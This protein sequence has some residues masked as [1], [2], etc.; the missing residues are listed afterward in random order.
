M[1]SEII[2]TTEPTQNRLQGTSNSQCDESLIHT[3]LY[4]S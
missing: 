2:M 1:K 4:A 3:H